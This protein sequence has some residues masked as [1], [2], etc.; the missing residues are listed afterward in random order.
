MHPLELALGLRL[1]M[2]KFIHS[3]LIFYGV[4][5]SQLSLAAWRTVLGFE[6]LC[7]YMLQRLVIVMF[8]VSHIC[9]G[10]PP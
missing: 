1:P 6:T 10:R 7:A 3:V 9:C 8:A 2:T 4:A 5:S